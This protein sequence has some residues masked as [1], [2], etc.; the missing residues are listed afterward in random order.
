MAEWDQFPEFLK[1][2]LKSRMKRLTRPKD[3][4][5]RV[6]TFFRAGREVPD[7]K[8]YLDFGDFITVGDGIYRGL[9]KSD[10]EWPRREA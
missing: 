3:G 2:H 10:V 6:K 1:A 7:G 8:W 4:V 5:K 9:K